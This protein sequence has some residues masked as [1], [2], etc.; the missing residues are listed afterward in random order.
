M[1]STKQSVLD[2]HDFQESRGIEHVISREAYDLKIENRERAFQ[3]VMNEQMEQI[4]E[5]EE[6][7]EENS[8]LPQHYEYDHEK[9]AIVYS[10]ATRRSVAAAYVNGF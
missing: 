4:L 9:I 2:S 5:Q 7:E 6:E 3:A 8:F 10:I 1:I